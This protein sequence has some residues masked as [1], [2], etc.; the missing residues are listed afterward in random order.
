MPQ[1]TNL[2]RTPYF[3]DFD[4]KK[5]FHKVLFKP[6]YSVQ[7]R[8]LTT[9]QSILQNQIEKFG[10]H[11]FKEGSRVI[12]GAVTHT[13]NYRSVQVEPEFSGLPLNLYQ[14]RLVGKEIKGSTSGVT[15]KIKNVATN[16]DTGNIILFIDYNESGSNFQ[17]N[18]FRDG[19][20]L[21]TLSD[22]SFGISNI[23]PSGEDFAKAINLN[24][25][26]VGSAAFISEGVYFIRG[27]FVRVSS[28]TLV[29]DN[30]G[31]KPSYR[32]GLYITEEIV[33]ADVDET[34]YDNSNGFS[35]YAAPGADRLK[36]S[37]TLIKKPLDNYDDA[38]FIEVLRLNGGVVEKVVD[39]TEYSIIA[40]ELARRTYDESGDYYITP[41]DVYPRNSLNDRIS[42]NG[43]FVE[44]QLTPSG[45]I[46][47][48]NLLT[49]KISPGKAYI[50]G[51]EV[52]KDSQ[53]FIDIDKPRSTNSISLEGIAFNC[54]PSL[55]VN[56]AYGQP[57]VG[58]A[59]TNYISLRDSRM[60]ADKTIPAGNEIGIAKAY[61]Y[62]FVNTTGITT[63]Y[64]LRVF[65]IQTFTTIGLSTNITLP[66]SALIEGKTSGA[67]GFLR[68][69]ASNSTTLTLQ[70]VSGRF[71]KDEGIVVSGISTY[72][73]VIKSIRDYKLSD[74]YSV[75]SYRSTATNTAGFNADLDLSGQFQ[76]ALNIPNESVSLTVPSFTIS[77]KDPDS[78]IS[79]VTST[80][81]NFIGI[82]TVGNIISYTRAGFSTITYNKISSISS[83]GKSVG[84]TAITNAFGIC[85]GDTTPV[86]INTSELSI[87]FSKIT[88]IDNPSLTAPLSKNNVSTIDTENTD[89]SLKRQ[90]NIASFS[91]NSITAPTLETDYTYQPYA[92]E[93]YVLTYSN[94]F[95]ETL[96]ADQF[97]FTNGFKNLQIKNL[98]I[99]SGSNATLIVSVKKEKVKEKIKKLNRVNSITVNR[100]S[101]N[102]SGVGNTTLNDGLV[103][104]QIYGTRVQDREISLNVPEVTN[105]LAIFESSD[106][107]APVI[108]SMTF[109]A[110][111]LTGPNKLATDVILGESV[112]GSESNAV[113]TV[114]SKSTNSIEFV[115]KNDS[116][117]VSGE[118][119][120]F[121]ESQINGTINTVAIG[122][123]NLLSKYKLDSGYRSSYYD[124]AKIVKIDPNFNPTKQL[125]I[126]F[127][128][129]YV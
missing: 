94:G 102:S 115:Y 119:V 27:Y 60:S 63:T 117:F 78:G 61:D 25:T 104:S 81:T 113:A 91:S 22:I 76:P 80:T 90:Y 10:Q 77:A 62:S 6:G 114:V 92:N 110:A 111:S 7:A 15:A 48:D 30:F 120:A 41:F 84:L 37:T 71:V 105:V 5:D 24:S 66:V 19:E 46:P 59:I 40:E 93:R 74:V 98:S 85:D 73:Q 12:P 121:K 112:I 9:L 36:I 49:Y 44:N 1:E 17:E 126:L 35:N 42:N 127:E 43:L 58:L 107:N 88:N 4:A 106:S 101:K 20:N 68:S 69:T 18:I 31:T 97:V 70:D 116:K 13:L 2:N 109:V 34:L 75:Y 108:P 23:I 96:T 67:R 32:V 86:Q 123:K 125:K 72:G 83:D 33:S 51:F 3:D 122:D 128:N 54:G 82:A 38:N 53:T 26:N 45:N 124:F 57:D 79:T 55:F 39:K 47:S 99:S 16:L 28:E 95:D 129:Y 100:S 11:F 87:R 29:L 8:E 52:T 118:I 14:T 89:L 103:Y 56:N 50:R 65:D 64:E 21:T